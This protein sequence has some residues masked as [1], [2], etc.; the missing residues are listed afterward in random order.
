MT[1]GEAGRVV[2]EVAN[3][4]ITN[5][6]RS[7]VVLFLYANG[8]RSEV[9]AVVPKLGPDAR[10]KVEVPAVLWGGTSFQAMVDPRNELAEADE[11]NNRTPVQSVQGES[12]PPQT[13]TT[14]PDL[15]TAILRVDAGPPLRVVARISNEG[16]LTSPATVATLTLASGATLSHDVPPLR[17]GQSI[18]VTFEAGEATD[19]VVMVDPAL[20]IAESDEANNRSDAAQPAAP[21]Q[22]QPQPAETAQAPVIVP[23]DSWLVGGV[24]VVIAPEILGEKR[25]VPG[26][27]AGAPARP[28][29][30][31]VLATGERIAFLEKEMLFTGT[32]AEAIALA[33]RY[34]GE[35]VRRIDRPTATGRPPSWSIAIDPLAAGALPERGA[36]EERPI[37]VSSLAAISL[38]SIVLQ[39][40]EQGTTVSLDLLVTP[41][42][43]FSGKT[44]EANG[45][46]SSEWSYLKKGGPL[47]VN[48]VG[49]WQ[50]LAMA[51]RP[52]NG[53]KVAIIDTGFGLVPDLPP[54]AGNTSYQEG[55]LAEGEEFHGASVASAVGAVAD[56]AMGAA[57]P[58]GQ[59]VNLLLLEF[60]YSQGDAIAALFV[61]ST[62]GALIIN[63]SFTDY[64]PR[65]TG[66]LETAW[67]DALDQYE[68]DT[69]Y[70]FESGLLLFASAGNEGLNVDELNSDGDES[71]WADPCENQGVICVGG[72]QEKG[73]RHY[74]SNYGEGRGETVDIYGP[75]EMRVGPDPL[76]S[77]P[78]TLFWAQGT[79]FASPFVAA[80][81]ALVWAANPGLLERPGLGAA[82]GQRHRWH[83]RH[84]DGECLSP[85]AA[86]AADARRQLSAAHP[87]E[88]ARL[89]LCQGQPI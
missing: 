67:N 75:Y 24:P 5:A 37:L 80:V 11:S 57:G 83:G 32:E 2:V 28:T 22:T 3:R 6:P 7:H 10:A 63:M 20:A 65:D 18:D 39:E 49:A 17:P 33:E 50:L 89:G 54:V 70:L 38:L 66:F 72:W 46:N 40:V 43:V 59:Y 9:E 55:E 27:R 14:V 85:G 73:T 48:V 13:V 77:A 4:G 62:Q 34:H 23:G 45:E 74:S 53:I 47:D 68:A 1:A 30:A 71:S 52:P 35:I 15:T 31:L 69:R 58:A 78:E 86:G 84:S 36:S 19:L 60:V 61:A 51:E 25:S 81:A 56:N 12:A 88:G 64:T 44:I 42:D 79:S 26:F 29:A 76:N 41:T 21:V 87:G 8:E 82:A 16:S